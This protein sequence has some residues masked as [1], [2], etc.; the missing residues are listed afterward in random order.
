MEL[1]KMSDM[2]EGLY[3]K[4][5][6]PARVAGREASKA[7][8]AI[9]K[10]DK[11]IDVTEKQISLTADKYTRAAY[12]KKLKQLV[13]YRN[14]LA[15]NIDLAHRASDYLT[16][17]Q[18]KSSAE[19]KS[20]EEEPKKEEPKEKEEPQLFRPEELPQVPKE[21]TKTKD[22]ISITKDMLDSIQKRALGESKNLFDKILFEMSE[23][24]ELDFLFR[25]WFKK[26]AEKMTSNQLKYY[27]NDIP[28]IRIDF[29]KDVLKKGG[30][31]SDVIEENPLLKRAL[32]D[33]LHR[34]HAVDKITGL[35]TSA[36][37]YPD[38]V[39]KFLDLLDQVPFSGKVGKQVTDVINK[40][41]SEI[42]KILMNKGKI[43]E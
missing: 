35:K 37:N 30:V 19:I 29:V 41:Y 10:L 23:S 11:Q 25:D 26:K 15:D 16:G 42:A 21:I 5:S 6:K 12:K 7:A 4:V 22:N 3:R 27:M 9:K 2:Q 20:K 40:A 34:K 28:E 33:Y 1:T 18:K 17:V 13:K 38:D 36:K 14:K 32:K 43:K 39:Q 31:S 24:N 8:K